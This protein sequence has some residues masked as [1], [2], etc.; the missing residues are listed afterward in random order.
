MP[1]SSS[2][3]SMLSCSLTDSES[4]P[5]A[6]PTWP[7]SPLSPDR[8]VLTPNFWAS[9]T[10]FSVPTLWMRSVN[11]VLDDWASAWATLIGP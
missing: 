2:V 7:M 4:W 9:W 6:I 5:R 1:L 8:V 11:A 10:T 3:A